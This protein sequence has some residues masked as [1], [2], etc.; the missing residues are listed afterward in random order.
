VGTNT[1]LDGKYS[2]NVPV[3]ATT[4]VYS[5]VGMKTQEVAI[6]GKTAIDVALQADVVGLS[7]VVVVAYGTESKRSVTGAITS[8]NSEA[9]SNQIAISPLRALQ[10]SAPG[11]NIL[12]TGGQPGVDPTIRIRGIG[13]VNA[14]QDPLIVVDGVVYNGSLSNIS[15]EQIESINT[16]KDASASSLYGSRASNGVIIITTKKGKFNSNASVTFSAKSGFSSPA[17]KTYNLVGA[18]DYMKYSWESLKN[19]YI[20]T[21]KLSEADAAANASAELIN[22]VGYNPFSVSSPI[23]ANGNVVSGA[24][25][26]WDTDWYDAMIRDKASYQDYSA[27]IRGGSDKISYFFSGNYLKQQGS[28]IESDF[29]RFSGRLNLDAK[30]NK[31]FNAGMTSSYSRS[32]Q[33]FPNQSGTSYTSTMQW[34]NSLSSIFPIYQRDENGAIVSDAK[35]QPLYDYGNS[36]GNVNGSRIMSG[37]NAVASTLLNQIRYKRNSF[38][39]TVYANLDIY[40]GLSFK[41]TL[42]YENYTYDS[43]EYDHYKYGSAA[44]VSGR[45]SQERNVT[46]S[47]T[48]T[49]NLKYQGTFGKHNI[50]ADA[51]S[52]VFSY[53]YDN[54]AS[55]GTGFLSNVYVLSGSTTPES[56]SGYINEE[57][58]ISYLGR[59]S[60]NFSEKY[61]LL[62]SYRR[63][64]STR[65]SSDNRWGD[66]YSVGANWI[67]SDESFLKGNSI[68]SFAK[69]RT[70]YGELGNNQGIGYFPYLSAFEAGWSNGDHPGVMQTGIAD[71]NITWEK[72]GLF[73]VGLDF[74]FLKDRIT[75][76]VEYYNKKS[77]DLI[78]DKPLAPSTGNTAITTNIGSIRNSGWELS[79]TTKNVASVNWEWTTSFNISTNKNEILSLPQEKITS[80]TKQ[81]MKGRSVYDFFIQEYAGVDPANGN[82]LWYEDVTD[83]NGNVIGRDTTNIYSNADRYYVGSSLPDY[84]GGFSSYLRYKNFD[85]NVMFNF[86][87]GSKIYDSSYAGLMSSLDATGYQLSEDI[88]GRWQKPG[89]ITDVPKLFSSNNDYNSQ[90]TR[91]LFDNNYLR[92]KALTIGYNIPK[93]LLNKVTIS[94]ARIYFQADNIWTLQSHKGLDPEQDIAG[95]TNN[96][97]YLMKT[98]SLGINVTF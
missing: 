63:D 70:S 82:A 76:T 15:A 69:L 58:L 14:S 26:L 64:G 12:T 9:I 3:S 65:F 7:E 78:F 51:I 30:V 34:V 17:V 89:D 87:T 56:V 40:K 43:Y 55:Q 85:V 71:Q 2:L 91:F 59:I 25:L 52:E 72:S 28:I 62:L 46:E 74:G 24:R 90:S 98:Y 27:E 84:I 35:G 68:V 21:N 94:D 73:N 8:M 13:S 93:S 45:V 22:H 77:I 80:G 29:D 81:L 97:S 95:T 88:E 47:Y 86:S 6:E 18:E 33:N 53:N 4:I 67:I 16:L 75:G 32:K 92:L 5:F 50:I 20:F 83:E 79:L 11:V 38:L 39:S 57:R 37:E 66:F 41:T 60:Y 1:D 19:T 44:S 23:D 36:S 31:W 61:Y 48:V 49:N 54:F 42:G 10:G 96:R